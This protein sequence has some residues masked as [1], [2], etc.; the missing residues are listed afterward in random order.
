MLVQP[1]SSYHATSPGRIGWLGVGGAVKS[2]GPMGNEIWIRLVAC[3]WAACLRPPGPQPPMPSFSMES[4]PSS[5]VLSASILPHSHLGV[6]D[7]LA[8]S[9][10]TGWNM[11][12]Y[13]A[14]PNPSG[15]KRTMIYC[16]FMLH[17]Q[18]GASRGSAPPPPLGG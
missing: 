8:V 15:L 7:K 11:P 4:R 18:W 2:T 6:D 1:E 14:T 9:V 16:L 12:W 3:P 5:Q 13:Q 10:R 17:A